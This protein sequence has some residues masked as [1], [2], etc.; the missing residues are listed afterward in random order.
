MLRSDLTMLSFF[1]QELARSNS[2]PDGAGPLSE[3]L[4]SSKRVVVEAE[5]FVLH[6]LHDCWEVVHHHKLPDWLKDNEYLIAGHRLPL[7]SF[8]ECFRSVF[9]IHTETGNIW[10]HLIGKLYIHVVT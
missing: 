3:F 6:V 10:T 2:A 4:S 9:R 7:N 1:Q 8:R 5:E